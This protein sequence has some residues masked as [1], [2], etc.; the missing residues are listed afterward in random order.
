MNSYAC[1]LLF[2][3]NCKSTAFWLGTYHVRVIDELK[4]V[5]MRNGHVVLVYVILVCGILETFL[6]EPAECD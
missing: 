6:F 3:Y 4:V 5:M 1:A 2:G